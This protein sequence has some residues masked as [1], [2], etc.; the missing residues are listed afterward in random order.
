MAFRP[1]LKH[2]NVLFNY[3]SWKEGKKN[4]KHF[5]LTDWLTKCNCTH[6]AMESTGVY[7]KQSTM[8]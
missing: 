6:V 4:L 5:Q 1:Q 7:W 2:E 3:N 8:Y